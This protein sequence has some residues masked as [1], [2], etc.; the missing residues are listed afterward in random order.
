[1]SEENKSCDTG[2]PKKKRLVKILIIVLVF[3]AGFFA[4]KLV[5]GSTCGVD[6]AEPAKNVSVT[7]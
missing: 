1:M 2:C 6:K 5:C 4:S 3:V 7:K